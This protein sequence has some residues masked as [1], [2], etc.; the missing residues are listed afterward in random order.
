[1]PL[2]PDD[3][4]ELPLTTLDAPVDYSFRC[5]DD[6]QPSR[7]TIMLPSSVHE[8]VLLGQGSIVWRYCTLLAG[9]TIGEGTVIGACVFLGRKCVIGDGV[10][11]HPGA[12][13][14]D[15]AVVGDEVYIGS[16]VTLTDVAVPDL[17]NKRNEVHRPPVIE[18]RVVI[19]CNA[20]LLPGVVIGRGAVVGAGAVVTRDVPPGATVAG[21]PAKLLLRG[22]RALRINEAGD[23][24]G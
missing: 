5:P 21:N 20:V 14:P 6:R 3:L 18:D 1:M 13:L 22:R 19:G 23:V 24:V 9:T 12:A 2:H 4:R 11:I 8:T 10:R 17:A 15:G 7:G 16:N